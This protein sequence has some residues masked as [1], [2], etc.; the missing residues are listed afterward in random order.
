MKLIYEKDLKLN[1]I[2]N[3]CSKCCFVDLPF[4]NN[5]AE[6]NFRSYLKSQINNPIDR[7]DQLS[8]K[9]SPQEYD[10]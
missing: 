5:L 3:I 7:Q 10:G 1:F 8:D 2:F 6:M 4:I 9:R